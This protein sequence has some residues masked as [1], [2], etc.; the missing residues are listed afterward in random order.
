MHAFQQAFIGIK[1][2]HLYHACDLLRLCSFALEPMLL[3]VFNA[4]CALF[5]GTENILNLIFRIPELICTYV[6]EVAC[7]EAFSNVV[8]SELSSP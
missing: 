5:D 2:L 1:S 6:M 8:A 3:V 7:L 4:V